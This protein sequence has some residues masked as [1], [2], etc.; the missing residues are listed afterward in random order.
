[1]FSSLLQYFKGMPTQL[2]F[3]QIYARTLPNPADPFTVSKAKSPWIEA[4]ELNK[5]RK[6]TFRFWNCERVGRLDMLASTPA[7]LGNGY[8]DPSSG[9]EHIT[10]SERQISIWATWN[11]LIGGFWS[12]KIVKCF[13][14]PSSRRMHI[15]LNDPGTCCML[16][17]WS[18]LI[19]FACLFFSFCVF[20]F[21]PF[22][23]LFLFLFLSSSSRVV[24]LF[25]HLHLI[26]SNPNKG[27]RSREY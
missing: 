12:C 25:P 15:A 7:N 1:M 24:F 19:F 22:P 9:T 20:F 2:F 27:R 8:T 26:F 3:S 18:L 17:S 23:S 13:V 6:S 10:I 14:G 4:S 11:S 16:S 21:L 5:L